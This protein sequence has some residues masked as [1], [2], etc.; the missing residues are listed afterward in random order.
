MSKAWCPLYVG[1]KVEG[2]RSP[3]KTKKNKKKTG[4]VYPLMAVHFLEPERVEKL[5]HRKL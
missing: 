2:R 1:N 5:V 3:K 4:C